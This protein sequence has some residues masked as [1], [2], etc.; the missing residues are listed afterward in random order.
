[1]ILFP[2]YRAFFFIIIILKVTLAVW[3]FT[4]FD[5]LLW[6]H[7]FWFMWTSFSPDLEHV[8][9]SSCVPLFVACQGLALIC[10]DAWKLV[11][12]IGCWIFSFPLFIF[13]LFNPLKLFIFYNDHCPVL[14][15]LFTAASSCAIDP[16]S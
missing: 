2:F 12:T 16:S 7:F 1:M 10:R 11:Q 5:F 14:A 6:G 8:S 3:P 4:L 15:Y 13:Y 9:S